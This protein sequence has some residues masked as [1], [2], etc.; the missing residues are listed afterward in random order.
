MYMAPE[1]LEESYGLPC[2]IWSVGVILYTLLAGR[3]PFE[4]SEWCL[5]IGFLRR[6]KMPHMER[7]GHALHPPGGRA[8][9]QDSE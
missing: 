8:P 9:F 1:V 3:T 6:L 2:D 7:G 5:P 4:D